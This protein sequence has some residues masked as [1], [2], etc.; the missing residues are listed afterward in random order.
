MIV[1]GRGVG[2]SG[3]W[4]SSERA[5]NMVC[6]PMIVKLPEFEIDSSACEG[7]STGA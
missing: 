6:E 5:T 2:G 1:G 3:A 7:A 4:I